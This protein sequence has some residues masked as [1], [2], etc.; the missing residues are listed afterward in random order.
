M[1]LRIKIKSKGAG[2]ITLHNGGEKRDRG[3]DIEDLNAVF[4]RFPFGIARLNREFEIREVNK[5]FEELLGLRRDEIVGK[6]LYDI[7]EDRSQGVP[8]GHLR[9]GDALVES[10]SVP[11]RDSSGGVSSYFFIIKDVT[12]DRRREK[13]TEGYIQSLEKKLER[14]RRE[15]N[16]RLD[17]SIEDRTR[18]LKEYS[19]HLERS[20]KLKE[21]FIEVLCHD[22]L[23]SVGI[24][25]NYLEL[26]LEDETD[27]RKLEELKSVER[28]LDKIISIIEDSNKYARLEA[29]KELELEKKDIGEIF[30][31]VVEK[32]KPLIEEKK[33]KLRF[34]P[35]RKYYS[36]V[37]ESMADVF[38]NLLSNAVKYSPVGGRVVVDILD[39]GNNWKVMVKDYG[40][41]VPD[42]DKKAIFERFEKKTKNGVKGSGLGLAIVKRAVELHKGQVWVED[43]P[44]GG[45]I[46]Y[47]SLPKAV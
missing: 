24:A 20:N 4:Q 40:E 6:N 46:F 18:E 14:M 33:I 10:W 26:L 36:L 5:A 15:F 9:L 8:P 47:V 39:N 41:G 12:G 23:N 28:R 21:T 30:R 16:E 45:S 17:K 2:G 25:K 3:P 11:V 22:L 27:P 7:A 37:D 34:R 1:G 44:D 29:T 13:I 19:Q 32:S 43:N 38:Q 31:N 35:W 42:K